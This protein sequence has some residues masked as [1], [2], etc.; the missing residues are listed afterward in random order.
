MGSFRAPGVQIREVDL[1]EVV[2]PAGTSVGALVG[3]TYKGPTNRRVLI[4][5]NSNFAEVFG[6]PV[7]GV[8]AEYPMY[9]GLEFLT[10][11]DFMYFVRPASKD[12]SVGALVF[13]ESI[14][15][16]RTSAAES[17]EGM[18]TGEFA[19]GNKSNLYYPGEMT[20]DGTLN[21]VALGA[22]D[23]NDDIG[24]SIITENDVETDNM[25]YT[26]G[27]SWAGKYPE[28]YSDGRPA[29]Y[30]RI[31][32]YK[33]DHQDTYSD[34]KW[35]SLSNNDKDP[36]KTEIPVE[37]WI[38]SNDPLAKDYQGNSM[39]AKTV[40]NGNSNYIYVNAVKDFETEASYMTEVS[41]YKCSTSGVPISAEFESTSGISG[42][43]KEDTLSWKIT[44]NWGAITSAEQDGF[45]YTLDTET[46]GN[47]HHSS[48]IGYGFRIFRKEPQDRIGSR[49]PEYRNSYQ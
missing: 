20:N 31:N 33:K 24:I 48:R 2:R 45:T 46:S 7:S 23:Y 42:F 11:S 22:S 41:S 13:D 35:D 37:S 38:V 17:G 19:D 32:V 1:S 36:S 9:C 21:I 34:A 47:L 18:W 6:T 49:K 10:E 4:T 27:Y 40:I 16:T 8:S 5:G 25:D 29:H 39:Y 3:P 30:Y 44:G 14:G 12:S 43:N 26:Y 28:K 15:A